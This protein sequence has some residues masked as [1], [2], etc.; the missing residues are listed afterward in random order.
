MG[1]AEEVDV[2]QWAVPRA[3]VQR[4]CGQSG[5]T[6]LSKGRAAS[7][8]LVLLPRMEGWAK[9]GVLP[10]KLT[11]LSLSCP[12]REPYSYQLRRQLLS[13]SYQC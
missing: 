9:L 11:G 7:P 6:L 12:Q 4:G 2:L 10:C 1:C 3:V 13:N 5:D 8:R